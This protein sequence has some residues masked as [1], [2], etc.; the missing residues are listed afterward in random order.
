MMPRTAIEPISRR[1]VSES[2]AGR[3]TQARLL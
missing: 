1:D 2:E 3:L